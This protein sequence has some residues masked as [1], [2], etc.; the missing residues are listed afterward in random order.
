MSKRKTMVAASLFLCLLL[1]GW[2]C[3]EGLK[4]AEISSGDQDLCVQKEK[5]EKGT[6]SVAG[7]A[8]DFFTPDTVTITLTVETTAKSADEA[9]AENSRKTE[10]AVKAVKLVITPAK[11]DSIKTSAFSVQPVYEYDSVKKRN[12]LTGYRAR[13]QVTV[14]TGK[15]EIAGKIIDGGIQN[16]ANEVE[17]VTFALTDLKEYCEGILKKA[18][19][20][21]QREAA[22]VARTFG[23]KLSGIKSISPAC[24]TEVPRPVYRQA[25]MAAQATSSSETAIEAGDIAVHASLSVVFYMEKE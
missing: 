22:F 2:A 10:R 21:T 23:M 3:A 6:I 9:V 17:G 8:K 19:D 7:E 18:A 12:L 15:I 5:G 11:G 13:H 14:R 25:L 4:P 24:G 1:A 20:K 16:G